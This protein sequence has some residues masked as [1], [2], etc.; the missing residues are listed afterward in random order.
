MLTRCRGVG[1]GVHCEYMY[2]NTK[3]RSYVLSQYHNVHRMCRLAQVQ[4]SP[5]ADASEPIFPSLPVKILH[6]HTH[7]PLARN[8]G[9]VQREKRETEKL[10]LHDFPCS[11][12]SQPPTSPSQASPS[13]A[14]QT[15][16]RASTTA[17]PASPPR[18]PPATPPPSTPWS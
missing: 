16:P 13:A 9:T 15:S 2:S 12:A 4:S 17:G 11:S 8:K 5:S 18:P 14:T 1:G 10:T 3:R 7:E 6:H